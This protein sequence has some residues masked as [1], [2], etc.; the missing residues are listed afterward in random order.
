MAIQLERLKI[1]LEIK[2]DDQNFLL[3]EMLESAKFAILSRRYPFGDFPVSDTGEPILEQRYCDLQVRIAVY[4]YNKMGAEG[5][6]AHSENGI[7]RSYEAGD[8]PESLL[9]Q[10][11]PLVS[12]PFNLEGNI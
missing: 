7:S 9:D 11:V 1:Q 6:I 2:D 12:I 5:Q 10:V 3:M 8:I 4:L